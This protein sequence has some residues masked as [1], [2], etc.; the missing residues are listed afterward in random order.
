[1]K[2]YRLQVKR[3]RALAKGIIEAR[4]RRMPLELLVRTSSKDETANALERVGKVK[5]V[6]EFIPYLSFA[7]G[8]DDA[9]HIR[10]ALLKKDGS[11]GYRQLARLIEAMDI[12]SK[13]ALPKPQKAGRA[14]SGFWNLENIGAYEAQKIGAGYDV[15]VAVIDTG[16]DYTHPELRNNFGSEKGYNF[17]DGK[18]PYDD[19]GHGTH[20]SGIIAGKK[21]G[22]ATDCQLYSLKVLN[23]DG[24][25]TE[26]D[27]MAAIEWALKKN[28]DIVNMS[29]G[30]PVASA[31]FEDMCYYAKSQGLLLV[32]AAGNNGYG[33]SYPAAFDD[34]VIAVA[35]VDYDNNHAD[36][37]NIYETNDISAPGVDITSSYPGG[38]E[39]LSGTS[40]AAPHVTGSLAIALGLSGSDDLEEIMEKTAT[41]LGERDEYGAGL[42][43]AF[44]IAKAV[45]GEEKGIFEIIK[46]VL[47]G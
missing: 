1:M 41:H 34:A 6:F 45:S 25:G 20:V 39:T 8:A 2:D 33:A 16:I 19:N 21:C 10:D 23:K 5:H 29:L 24:E 35:A 4:Q 18:E 37:S 36:F 30:A 13:V 44:G 12:S 7:C 17:V 47:W 27:S 11:N 26:A 42:I 43:N 28:V 40:M 38:Y 9:E 46:E 15:K 32:A 31:A 22:I 14:M 3:E